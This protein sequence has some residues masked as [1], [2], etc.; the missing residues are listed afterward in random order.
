MAIYRKPCGWPEDANKHKTWSLLRSLCTNTNLLVVK[1]QGLKE[2]IIESDAQVLVSRL[3]RATLYFSDLD[4][5]LGDILSL[6]SSFLS[7]CFFSC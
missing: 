5:I 3:T 6:Y 4:A 1:K 7:I 2:I